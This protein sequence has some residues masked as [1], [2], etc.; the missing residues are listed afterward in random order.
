M[1]HDFFIVFIFHLL[2]VHFFSPRRANMGQGWWTAVFG[3][4][5]DFSP[6][7]YHSHHITLHLDRISLYPNFISF[8]QHCSHKPSSATIYT[9]SWLM[10]FFVLSVR[11][12]PHWHSSSR[13]FP[14]FLLFPLSFLLS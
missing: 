5:H 14:L 3:F 10:T 13:P 12:S 1:R 4:E 2:F 6:P 8:Y 11:L 7:F 9:L